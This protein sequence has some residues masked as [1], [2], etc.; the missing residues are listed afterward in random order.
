MATDYKIYVVNQSA[1]GQTFWAF[2]SK[3]EISNTEDVFANSNTNIYIPGGSTS[4][5]L[6]TIP[7]QYMI[8]AG[9]SNNAV[10]LNTKIES[11]STRKTDLDQL[12]NV[13]YYTVPPNQGPSIPKASTGPSTAKTIA[14]ATSAYN[15]S[16]NEG[17]GWYG[18][19][20]FG[21]QTSQGFMGVT[22]SPDPQM[23]YTITPELSFYIAVG[24]YHAYSLASINA[25]SSGSAKCDTA[26][27]FNSI[28][29][30]TV[31]YTA[32]GSWEVTEGKPTKT[33]LE[34]AKKN[35]LNALE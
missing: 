27:S 13:T 25:V 16:T 1:N 22:W 2:L 10:G 31:T 3:P 12:W 30:C 11:N 9:A 32:N 19:M 33:M 29:E 8:G 21:V 4:I 35:M 18:N 14:M 23:T 7:V 20:S 17:Y 6:F 24:D 28:N 5:N 34:V 26:S 15:K